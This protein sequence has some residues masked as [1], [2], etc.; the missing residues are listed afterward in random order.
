MNTHEQRLRWLQTHHFNSLSLDRN[1]DHRCNYMTAAAWM[2][3]SPDDFSDVAPEV[4]QQ[5][6]DTD[7]IW[8]LQ[9][10]PDSPVGFLV[11]HGPTAEY[12]ID[13]AMAHFE[14]AK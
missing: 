8:R 1:G 9:I 11:W 4:K 5:M 7:T 3:Y 2:L 14:R 12:V 10:Y 13:A 6:A